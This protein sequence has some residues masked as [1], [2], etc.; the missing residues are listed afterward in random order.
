LDEPRRDNDAN[1]ERGRGSGASGV[2]LAIGPGVSGIGLVGSGSEVG[3]SPA[4]LAEDEDGCT[5]SGS[6]ASEIRRSGLKEGGQSTSREA[7]EC[8]YMYKI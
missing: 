1:H 4:L 8:A 7:S 2:G 3:G 5:W 6:R